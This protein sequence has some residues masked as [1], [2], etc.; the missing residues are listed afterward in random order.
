VIGEELAYAGSSAGVTLQSDIT[1]DYLIDY[2]SEEQ[3]KRFL[4]GMVSGEIITAIAMTEPGAS[5]DLQGARTTA[6]R[7]GEHWGAHEIP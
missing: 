7:D 1:V 6:R 3:T 2:G 4:P 5:S